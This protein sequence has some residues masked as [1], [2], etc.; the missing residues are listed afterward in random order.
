MKRSFTRNIDSLE[1]I[2]KFIETFSN[3]HALDKQLHLTINLAVE[4]LFTNAVK[5]NPDI[6]NKV[7]IE[8]SKSNDI[9]TI[10]IVDYADEPFNLNKVPEYDITAPLQGRPIG[11]LG[12]HFI[13]NMFTTVNH[14]FKNNQ[15]K[16]VLT[17][18]LRKEDA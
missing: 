14:E 1:K 12:I 15:S 13:K 18:K 10:S 11:K 9:L 8:F 7:L 4:E 16:I 17:K 5:Y 2:F 6:P 3:K